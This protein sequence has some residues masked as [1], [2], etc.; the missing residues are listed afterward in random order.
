MGAQVA[1]IAAGAVAAV[2]PL[3]LTLVNGFATRFASLFREYAIVGAS[4][5]IRLNNTA[6]TAGIIEAFIDEETNAAP[7]ANDAANRP[8]LDM[9]VG[10]IFEPRAYRMKWKPRD[11]LDLDYVAT[12]TTFTPAWLKVFGSV[13][14]TFTTATTTGQV[15]VTGTLAFCFRGYV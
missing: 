3:D 2:F 9:T 6:V 7:T 10:P 14:N 1:S 13:A 11:I 8:R 4:I 15:I 5:E 12:G